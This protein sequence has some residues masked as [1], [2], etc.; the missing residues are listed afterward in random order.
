MACF[1][2]TSWSASSP[3]KPLPP[4]GVPDGL[5]EEQLVRPVLMLP[6]FQELGIKRLHELLNQRQHYIV[7]FT[8]LQHVHVVQLLLYDEVGHPLNIPADHVED[9]PLSSL[10]IE[11]SFL[12]NRQ[13][14][15]LL[16]SPG[17]SLSLL[18]KSLR[19]LDDALI[20]LDKVLLLRSRLRT[21]R[22]QLAR[23]LR[24]PN[25]G[26]LTFSQPIPAIFFH[27]FLFQLLL[28]LVLL[29]DKA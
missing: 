12:G 21:G 6:S 20:S 27:D 25:V 28:Q 24:K 15:S 11:V 8:M 2:R 19:I 16:V 3:G 10:E 14:L 5:D 9:P 26:V 4:D 13:Y 17:E 23:H 7:G 18:R 22:E 1:K 29:L